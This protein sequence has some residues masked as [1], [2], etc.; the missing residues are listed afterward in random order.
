MGTPIINQPQV[1]ILAIGVIR[2]LPSV[3]ETPNGD[4]IGIRKKLILSHS[5]D[6]RII[7]GSVGSSFVK[8][9]GEYLEKW[10]ISQSI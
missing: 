3:I 2:K 10:D 4:F 8:R 9:V 5:Y 1:G 7:N 6:H